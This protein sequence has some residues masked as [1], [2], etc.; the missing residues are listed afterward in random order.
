MEIQR[1]LTGVD[2]TWSGPDPAGGE[3]ATGGAGTNPAAEPPTALVRGGGCYTLGLRR[4][5]TAETVR[6][7][8]ANEAIRRG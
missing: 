7:R 4:N 6:S 1:A 5:R 8:L 2:L 3:E